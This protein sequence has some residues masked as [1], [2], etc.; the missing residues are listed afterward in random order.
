MA[1]MLDEFDGI[2]ESKLHHQSFPCPSLG[3]GI[4]ELAPL[5]RWLT[6]ACILSSLN[7]FNV[8]WVRKSEHQ[9]N[10]LL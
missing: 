7:T 6:R 3:I 2:D 1:Q 4:K 8:F 10:N 9:K 5:P